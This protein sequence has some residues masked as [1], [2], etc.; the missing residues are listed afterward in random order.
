MYQLRSIA[1]VFL[2]SQIRVSSNLNLWGTLIGQDLCLLVRGQVIGKQIT[3]DM[4]LEL[5]QWDFP[6]H[7]AHWK[8]NL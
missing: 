7:D 8:L 5:P 6:Y 3:R 4:D 2:I 1:T